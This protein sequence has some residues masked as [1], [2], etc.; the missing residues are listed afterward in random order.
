MIQRIE[1][2][3]SFSIGNTVE[4]EGRIGKDDKGIG[5]L[6]QLLTHLYSDKEAVILQELTANSHDSYKRI[7][8]D[9]IVTIEYNDVD[10]TLHI[11]D[12]AEGISPEVFNKYFVELGGS[13][14]ELEVESA[15]TLGIGSF[16]SWCVTDTFYLT[17][18]FNNVKY[19]YSCFRE[20]YKKPIFSLLMQEE[21]N[22]IN[23]TDYWFYT[24]DRY[25][26]EKALSKLRYFENVFVKGIQFDNNYKIIQGETFMY[27]N[28]FPTLNYELEIC[29]GNTPYPINWS[30]LGIN[31]INVPLAL[32]ID[33]K[34]SLTILPSRELLGWDAYTIK[35]VTDKIEEFKKEIHE[36]YK[37]E[38]EKSFDNILDYYF[39]MNHKNFVTLNGVR[40]NISDLKFPVPNIQYSKLID[41]MKIP[42]YGFID[43]FFSFKYINRKDSYGNQLYYYKMKDFYFTEKSLNPRKSK[44]ING[45][46]VCIVKRNDFIVENNYNVYEKQQYFIE[47]VANQEN[48]NDLINQFVNNVEQDLKDVLLK[49]D[50][51]IVPKKQ[52]TKVKRDKAIIFARINNDSEKSNYDVNNLKAQYIFL[53]DNKV[54]YQDMIN[55]LNPYLDKRKCV[56]VIYTAKSNFK[57]FDKNVITLKEWFKT[58]MFKTIYQRT[59]NKEYFNK[60][61]SYYFKQFLEI[62]K[63]EFYKLIKNDR[64][65]GTYNYNY[66]MLMGAKL[67]YNKNIVKCSMLEEQYDI[68]LN[69]RK[70]IEYQKLFMLNRLYKKQINKLKSCKILN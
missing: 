37:L 67:E 39:A 45:R 46:G 49:Y 2:T 17:T 60:F 61:S 34:E 28:K 38:H 50:D 7:K 31:K 47:S 9:G 69:S 70:E 57:L 58:D 44:L 22:E 68:Y 56:L 21:C 35:V 43:K 12:E 3:D 11:I 6:F 19:Y 18:V 10:E 27:N 13:S 54:E 4:I 40:F 29:F 23:G 66:I 33:L 14:K 30:L 8:K 52:Y 48:C 32:K 20:Q 36:I 42:D 55:Y 64:E 16:A 15:G 65:F 41:G 24:R 62:Y 25:K 59:S 63:K 26:F 51:I 5:K 53:T 1:Q